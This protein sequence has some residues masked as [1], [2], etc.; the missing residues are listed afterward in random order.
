MPLLRKIKQLIKI[1]L[2]RYNQYKIEYIYTLLFLGVELLFV[3][4]WY[5]LLGLNGG[6]LAGW[7]FP[8]IAILMFLYNLV[9]TLVEMVGYYDMRNLLIGGKRAQISILLTK[10]IHP[11]LYSSLRY[12]YLPGLLKAL[13]YTGFIIYIFYAYSITL[14]LSFFILVIYAF[15]LHGILMYIIPL[16]YIAYE[17]NAEFI[18]YLLES[19]AYNAN[20]PYT[21]LEGLWGVVFR[22][23]V[24]IA[25]MAAIPAFCVDAFCPKYIVTGG[26]VVLVFLA[27]TK[28]LSIYAWKRFEA[29]GG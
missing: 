17:K 11:F 26:V 10:P 28:L 5:G 18:R 27:L 20:M 25:F 22:F 1:G 8:K 9:N 12:F 6:T 24:P 21:A 16:L 7:T 3:L 14:S 2:E 4:M 13:I 15:I 19:F 23:V 29:V